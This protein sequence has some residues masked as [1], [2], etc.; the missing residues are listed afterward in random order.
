MVSVKG[1]VVRATAV[2]PLPTEVAL[3]CLKCGG[4]F[5]HKLR[6]GVYSAPKSCG[7]SPR[8]KA[9]K[10]KPLMQQSPC[11]DWQ[12][13]RLQENQA[14]KGSEEGR[15]PRMVECELSDGLVDSCKAG[16]IVTVL[17][18]VKV[19]SQAADL[20]GGGGQPG[21]QLMS[22]YIEAV[23]VTKNKQEGGVDSESEAASRKRS[24]SSGLSARDIDFVSKFGS[25]YKEDHL[26]QLVHSLAPSISGHT[27]VKAGM[28][29]ALCGGMQKNSESKSRV[30]IRG[31]THMLLVGEPGIGK[32]Q[33]L[34]A[35]AGVAPRCGSNVHTHC[36][37]QRRSLIS[38]HFFHCRGL[39]VCGNV[40]SSVGLTVSVQKDSVSGEY[41]FEAGAAVMADRGACCI[42]EFDKMPNGEQSGL[43]EVME[44][45]SVSVSKAGL[46]ANLP[47]RTTVMAAA[48]PAKGTYDKAKSVTE[49]L[50]MGAALLSRFDLAFIM[51][52]KPDEDFDT[53]ASA[54]ILAQYAGKQSDAGVRE[55]LL[56]H[57]SVMSQGAAGLSRS[58]AQGEEAEPSLQQRLQYG[59]GKVR[60]KHFP[61]HCTVLPTHCAGLYV[62]QD[63]DPIPSQLIQ[64]YITYV[65]HF[66]HPKLTREASKVR[67]I[68]CMQRSAGAR[69]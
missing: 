33:L 29:L 7:A 52:D 8:C 65:R 37:T 18:I 49:N 54:R 17:G 50:R 58:G 14:G 40:S 43:L 5:T 26:R 63:F 56:E 41:S 38:L 19:M 28:I 57:S 16:D 15:I 9:Q 20:G 39:Y 36:F 46:T 69:P 11:R 31:N 67:F 59:C 55:K 21:S 62:M 44:Q 68:P 23:S 1:A 45:Q 24:S 51:L 35:V 10:F 53:R 27:M 2:K 13:V 30:P 22:Q 34:K 66:V 48:N 61:G 47:A 25:E 64:K 42:D 4:T 3:H 60:M 6:D 32:S 12:R